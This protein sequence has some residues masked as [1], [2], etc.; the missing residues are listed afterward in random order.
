MDTKFRTNP[1]QRKHRY[2]ECTSQG[3]SLC[4]ITTR[5]K[6]R[7]GKSLLSDSLIKKLKIYSQNDP[8][9]SIVGDEQ[10]S[11]T[12]SKRKDSE[13]GVR[14]SLKT[15]VS[16]MDSRPRTAYNT[17]KNRMSMSRDFGSNELSNIRQFEKQIKDTEVHNGIHPGLPLKGEGANELRFD[18]LINDLMP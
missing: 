18:L 17:H 14:Q 15:S 4:S 8:K 12:T 16:S 6:I 2:P 9:P 11:T 7:N 5:S 1:L 3:R 13:G 10:A